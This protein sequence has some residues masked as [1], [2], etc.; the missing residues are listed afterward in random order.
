MVF[1]S[2]EGRGCEVQVE[3]SFF[4]ESFLVDGVETPVHMVLV[5][6]EFKVHPDGP[7]YKCTYEVQE[8]KEG[9]WI[10]VE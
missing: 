4:G 2:C 5:G 9:A 6:T 10:T 7:A 1:G 3:R 8:N